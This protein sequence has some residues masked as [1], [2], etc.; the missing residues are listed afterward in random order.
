MTAIRDHLP[1][2]L[3]DLASH[4]E[5]HGFIL[6]EDVQE[7]ISFGDGVLEWALKG[8]ARIRFVKD[9]GRWWIELGMVRGSWFSP[10]VCAALVD[11]TWATPQALNVEE[12]ANEV[13]RYLGEFL[14]MLDEKDNG[15]LETKLGEIQSR[16]AEERSRQ[17]GW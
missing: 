16:A 2:P 17:L 3:D 6:T 12:Q 11:G 7:P 5:A 13:V 14:T 15:V 9:R 10:Q 4:L 1:L 8:R